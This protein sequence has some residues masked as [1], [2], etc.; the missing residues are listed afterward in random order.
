MIALR[1][2]DI[3]RLSVSGSAAHLSRCYF[4]KARLHRRIN[5]VLFSITFGLIAVVVRTS[6]HGQ[7]Y[8][9]NV[10]GSGIGGSGSW[11]IGGTNWNTASTGEDATLTPWANGDSAIFAGTAGVVT[12]LSGL[13]ANTVTVNT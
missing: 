1:K 6:A 3:Q 11:G 7:I 13:S 10:S 2:S 4:T 12:V 5:F 9:D 8:W